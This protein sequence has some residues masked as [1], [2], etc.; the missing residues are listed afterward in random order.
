MVQKDKLYCEAGYCKKCFE[1]AGKNFIVEPAL[2]DLGSSW[3]STAITNQHLNS[4]ALSIEQSILKG[5]GKRK[6]AER[7]SVP[8]RSIKTGI[9]IIPKTPRQA[10]L[11]ESQDVQSEMPKAN[12]GFFKEQ[13]IKKPKRK[14]MISIENKLGTSRRYPDNIQRSSKINQACSKISDSE[15][16]QNKSDGLI[17]SEKPDDKDMEVTDQ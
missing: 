1:A 11:D 6:S 4:N 3:K 14:K 17:A 12:Q 9:S 15:D 8:K 2:L 5:P 7:K 13:D 10:A 16:L